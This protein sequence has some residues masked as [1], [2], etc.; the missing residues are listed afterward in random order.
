[1]SNDRPYF[2]GHYVLDAGR[3]KKP[4]KKS[5]KKFNKWTYPG[6]IDRELSSSMKGPMPKIGWGHKNTEK[7]LHPCNLL[8][9]YVNNLNDINKLKSGQ[10]IAVRFKS[11]IGAKKRTEFRKILESKKIKYLN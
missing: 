1:M 3:G 7:F 2:R 8:E 9:V 5:R 11:T 10:K 6:G 4:G